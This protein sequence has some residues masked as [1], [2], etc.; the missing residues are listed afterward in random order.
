MTDIRTVDVLSFRLHALLP[1][2]LCSKPAELDGFTAA[3]GGSSDGIFG[4]SS[5]PELRNHRNALG[6]D[7]GGGRV[8]VGVHK[9][10]GDVLG[11][12]EMRR[13]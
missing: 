11:H 9:V 10:L 13:D 2:L 7:F 3:G 1:H 12:A 6:V 4:I 5:M 8:L